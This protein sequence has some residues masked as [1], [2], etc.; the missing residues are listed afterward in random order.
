MYRRRR[1]Q[2]ADWFLMA[3]VALTPLA[4]AVLSSAGNDT[5]AWYAS[6]VAWPRFDPVVA[7]ALLPLLA[8]LARRP[9]V[10]ASA[11]TGPDLTPAAA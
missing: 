7:I 6:P 4:L 5:L 9:S 1:L 11:G 10:P 3:A 2:G 8:P